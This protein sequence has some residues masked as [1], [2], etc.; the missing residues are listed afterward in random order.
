MK[1][2]TLTPGQIFSLAISSKMQRSAFFRGPG[3]E[4][5]FSLQLLKVYQTW[6]SCSLWAQPQCKCRGDLF[7]EDNTTVFQKTH[8]RV[9]PFGRARECAFE[10]VKI[11][12]TTDVV[13]SP[14]MFPSLYPLHQRAAAVVTTGCLLSSY[15]EAWKPTK[16]CFILLPPMEGTLKQR[17]IFSDCTHLS[18]T[19]NYIFMMC[20]R[21]AQKSSWKVNP[22]DFGGC[23]CVWYTMQERKESTWCCKRAANCTLALWSCGVWPVT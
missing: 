15:G 6:Y 9:I 2:C 16:Y 7:L 22:I 11:L 14:A 12:E 21:T 13:L 18:N 10:T 23:L 3:S 20:H 19:G 8:N 4:I 5:Q 17:E 1:L